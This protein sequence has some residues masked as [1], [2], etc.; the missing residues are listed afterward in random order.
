MRCSY[1]NTEIPDGSRFCPVCGAKLSESA[2]VSA[3]PASSASD[4]LSGIQAN[5]PAAAALVAELEKAGA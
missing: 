5:A 4:I 1:C 3:P 2:P